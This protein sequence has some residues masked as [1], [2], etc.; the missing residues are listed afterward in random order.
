MA[1]L[2]ILVILAYTIQK[3]IGKAKWVNY[4]INKL[5]HQRKLRKRGIMTTNSLS[6]I[7]FHG[8]SE[9]Q[10]KNHANTEV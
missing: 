5:T 4:K 8:N 9:I 6:T 1:W 3:W 7:Y 2:L 10:N